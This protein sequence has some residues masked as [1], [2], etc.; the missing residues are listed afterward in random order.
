MIAIDDFIDQFSTVF[1][2]VKE[3]DP[4]MITQNLPATVQL[5]IRDLDDSYVVQNGIAI[6]R[7]AIVEMGAVLK[8]PIILAENSFVGAHAYLR[9]GVYVGS[10]SRIGPGCELKSSLI[11]AHTASAHF[12]FI[13]DSIIGNNVNFEAGS[14]IANHFNEKNGSDKLIRVRYQNTAIETNMVKFGALVGDGSRIG[15]NAVLSPGT[16]LPRQ[17]IVK[18]L[19]L[20]DQ[21]A[22]RQLS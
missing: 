20:V 1:S 16:I 15:A 8:P 11:L 9:G 12:N 5:M 19:E 17:S 3:L 14:V 4:W 2:S 22:I 13:G 21:Q 7:T 10:G 6:H 18:R